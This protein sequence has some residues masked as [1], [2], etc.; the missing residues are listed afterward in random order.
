MKGGREGGREGKREE[1]REERIGVKEEGGREGN[2]QSHHF[3]PLSRHPL[4]PLPVPPS[5]SFLPL[6][7]SCL[8]SSLRRT[9]SKVC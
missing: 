8:P 4:F 5:P 2:C 6:T 3:L 9:F 7:R 1:R